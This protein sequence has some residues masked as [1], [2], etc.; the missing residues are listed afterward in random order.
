MGA[1]HHLLVVDDE[2]A[3]CEVIKAGFEASGSYRVRC[4][5]NKHDAVAAL[6]HRPFDL[7][8]IDIVMRENA[9][10]D[11]E[12]L[13]GE[14]RVPVLRMTGHPDVICKTFDQGVPVLA[15]PFRIG[16]VI[17][18]VDQLL[19]DAERLQRDLAQS[20]SVGRALRSKSRT[21]LAATPLEWGEAAVQWH[22]LCARVLKDPRT[23]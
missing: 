8:L 11:V 5:T 4:A 20:M 12:A 6:R 21:G 7:A 3:I 1:M 15:K 13:A 10:S 19:A 17:G 14:L 16:D 18:A 22:R 2:R 23:R 9:G